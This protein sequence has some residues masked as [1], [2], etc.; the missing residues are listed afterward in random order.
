MSTYRTDLLLCGGTGCIA[1]G[2]L[3]VKEATE[4][5]FKIGEE[6]REVGR[7]IEP[8]QNGL[9]VGDKLSGHDRD[10]NQQQNPTTNN[11]STVLLENLP[12]PPIERRDFDKA[13][14]FAIA[15]LIER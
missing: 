6:N 4:I 9:I 11:G 1:S 12:P 5:C 15:G 3:E 10:T 7:A 2:S 14:N 8:D 13:Q